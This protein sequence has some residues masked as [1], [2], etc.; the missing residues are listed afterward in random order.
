MFGEARGE[1]LQCG[2]APGV[3]A[4]LRL[5]AFARPEDAAGAPP[6]G[7]PSDICGAVH[8]ARAVGWQAAALRL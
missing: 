3:T 1:G 5:G 4:H 6:I 7:T 8:R 2:R